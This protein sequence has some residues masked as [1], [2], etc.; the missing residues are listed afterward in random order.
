MEEAIRVCGSWCLLA[1]LWPKPTLRN[2]QGKKKELLKY[3][4]DPVVELSQQHI[5]KVTGSTRFRVSKIWAP[6]K[7]I[8]LILTIIKQTQK[9]SFRKFSSPSI[10]GPRKCVP[11]TVCSPSTR[12]PENPE[13]AAEGA[14]VQYPG[15]STWPRP[16]HWRYWNTN[17]AGVGWGGAELLYW[18]WRWRKGAISQEMWV[19]LQDEK[20]KEMHSFLE[21]PERNAALPTSWF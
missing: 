6:G 21:L 10:C 18:L 4:D 11:C 12:R 1:Q 19:P 5:T 8:A 7:C 14:A 3:L 13:S 15:Q 17:W 16:E 2:L 9:G 20:G